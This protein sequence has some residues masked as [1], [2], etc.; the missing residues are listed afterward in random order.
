MHINTFDII[1]LD[2]KTAI[3]WV[4]SHAESAHQSKKKHTQTWGQIWMIQL[5]Y[6]SDLIRAEVSSCLSLLCLQIKQPL[7]KVVFNLYNFVLS[8]SS[9]KVNEVCSLFIFCKRKQ[10]KMTFSLMGLGHLYPSYS[11]I[12]WEIQLL[13]PLSEWWIICTAI[14]K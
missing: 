2:C 14:G 7:E 6:S 11:G 9:M 4:I 1:L 3:I 8:C 10:C 5:R 12:N 13:H